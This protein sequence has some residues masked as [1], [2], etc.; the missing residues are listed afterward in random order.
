MGRRGDDNT[1]GFSASHPIW[2]LD[3]D[4]DHRHQPCFFPLGH[5]ISGSLMFLAHDSW[6]VHRICVVHH[7]HHGIWFCS[8]GIF[9]PGEEAAPFADGSSFCADLKMTRMDFMGYRNSGSGSTLPR[10]TLTHTWPLID[11]K[12]TLLYYIDFTIHRI[13]HSILSH[14]YYPINPII[15]FPYEIQY[16]LPPGGKLQGWFAVPRR[17]C[18]TFDRREDGCG[19]QQ[20]KQLGLES[21]VT[22]GTVAA[23]IGIEIAW[24][25]MTVASLGWWMGNGWKWVMA[26]YSL[27]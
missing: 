27:L 19:P 6:C 8:A 24:W 17:T 20:P 10:R 1:C 11:F 15:L 21:A 5:L 3:D 9:V 25:R 18:W 26:C 22:S 12:K 2:A 13:Q 7:D 16:M 4:R 14:L 23:T